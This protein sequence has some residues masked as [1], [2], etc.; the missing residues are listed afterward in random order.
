[1]LIGI[2]NSTKQVLGTLL[3]SPSILDEKNFNLNMDDFVEN[4][5]KNLPFFRRLREESKSPS[6]LSIF[7]EFA[8]TSAGK[9]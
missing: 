8:R 4:H 2:N 1:M 9:L 6:L 7:R 3:K 5:H